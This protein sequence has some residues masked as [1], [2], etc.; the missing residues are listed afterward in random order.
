[1][2]LLVRLNQLKR[3]GIE[4]AD[5]VEIVKRGLPL[6]LDVATGSLARVR[7]QEHVETLQ[8]GSPERLQAIHNRNAA[9]AKVS[10]ALAELTMEE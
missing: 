8:Q 4:Y 1:M 7:W 5:D 10:N 2:N 9:S 6:L 3:R